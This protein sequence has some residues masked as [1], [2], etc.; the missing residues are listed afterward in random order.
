M[1]A[2]TAYI[3]GTA[4]TEQLTLLEQEKAGEQERQWREEQKKEGYTYKARQWMFGGLK[5]EEADA[6]E[7]LNVERASVVEAVDAKRAETLTPPEAPSEQGADGK[8]GGSGSKWSWT[9]WV[10]G[11]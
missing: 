5:K 7:T 2:K 11:R 8:Q 10:T 4:T 6:A 3:Q 1:D 9:G